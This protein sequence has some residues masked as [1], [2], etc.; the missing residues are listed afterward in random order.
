[1]FFQSFYKKKDL[2]K[3]PGDKWGRA[4]KPSRPDYLM[5]TTTLK[6]NVLCAFYRRARLSRSESVL[7]GASAKKKNAPRFSFV[8]PGWKCSHRCQL[9]HVF[10]DTQELTHIPKVRIQFAE[11]LYLHFPIYYSLGGCGVLM[12]F[13]T[14]SFFENIYHSLI[15]WLKSYRFL[16]PWTK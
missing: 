11:F 10:F 13:G 8:W 7:A 5:E 2:W 4:H 3:H 6:L 1:M 16:L 15:L 12:R 14:A 9:R